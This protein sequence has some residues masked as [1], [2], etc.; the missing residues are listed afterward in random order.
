MSGTVPSDV[1]R[2][3]VL[4]LVALSL[5]LFSGC[6]GGNTEE[7]P[8]ADPG[9]Q[10]LEAMQGTWIT[11]RVSEGGVLAEDAD[12]RATK[13]VVKGDTY[14]LTMGK[15]VLEGTLKLDATKK[16]KQ[17]DITLDKGPNAGKVV[18]GIYAL[19]G[20][21]LEVCLGQPGGGRPED[22][23]STVEGQKVFTHQRPKR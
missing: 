15:N 5:M 11:T 7:K 16:P 22:F 12:I 23:D 6:S 2:G 14:T 3:R 20:G 21:V 9:K 13:L 8:K 4:L 18:K 19:K 1:R 17:L 10:D